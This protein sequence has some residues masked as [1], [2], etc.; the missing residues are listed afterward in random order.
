M[1]YLFWVFNC[2]QI[3]DTYHKSFSVY[4]DKVFCRVYFVMH[5]CIPNIPGTEP[6]R[7]R[8][9]ANPCLSSI[10]K[11]VKCQQYPFWVNIHR[12][13][14]ASTALSLFENIYS[15]NAGSIHIVL[16]IREYL[17]G[18]CHID[19]VLVIREYLCL[20]G[21]CHIDIVLVIREYL[22]LPGKC[23]IDIVLV[24]REYLPG[25][26]HID[27]VLVIREYLCLPGK[28]HMHIVLDFRDINH[29][30]YRSRHSRIRLK[31]CICRYR[32]P[33]S[34]RRQCNIYRSDL[35]GKA[36]ENCHLNPLVPNPI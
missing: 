19:I 9:F 13:N 31:R 17:P 27:I 7:C 22:C 20:P 2:S 30:P 10:A 23:H 24:I 29:Q 8:I 32:S 18:K 36:T 4:Y 15:E 34:L 14:V 1:N 35:L 26:C 28:S 33:G 5:A 21:K 6:H 25:K 12:E 16:V 11:I 3:T